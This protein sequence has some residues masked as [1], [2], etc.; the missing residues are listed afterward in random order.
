MRDVVK[1]KL[2][3][4]K[5]AYENHN[6]GPIDEE[7]D[8][9]EDGDGE[10]EWVPETH[11]RKG[12]GTKKPDKRKKSGVSDEGRDDADYVERQKFHAKQVS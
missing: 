3:S 2:D 1:M 6:V 4:E 7:E 9:E 8:T 5:E 12:N 10:E 11:K